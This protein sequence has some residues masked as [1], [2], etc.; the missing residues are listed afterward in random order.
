MNP[1]LR[2]LA[3]KFAEFYVQKHRDYDKARQEVLSLQ[4]TKFDFVLTATERRLRITLLRPGLLIGTK[5]K[6][7]EKLTEFL[8]I[9]IHIVEDTSEMRFLLPEPENDLDYWDEPAF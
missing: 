4:V 8:N 3:R 9:K 5:G 2:D 7:I 6:N 1:A